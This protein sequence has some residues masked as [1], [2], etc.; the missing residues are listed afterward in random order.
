MPFILHINIVGTDIQGK[1]WEKEVSSPDLHLYIITLIVG[2]HRALPD[3]LAM[4]EI[5]THPSLVRCLSDL[6]I[7]T[8]DKQVSMWIQQK[9]AHLRTTTNEVLG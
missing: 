8:P 3:V 6:I 2:A 7:R 9:Q 5:L 1:D 4:E